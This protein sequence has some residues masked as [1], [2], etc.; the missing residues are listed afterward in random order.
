MANVTT[1]KH[2]ILIISDVS[3]LNQD[4]EVS[5][6][7]RLFEGLTIPQLETLRDHYIT[8]G[9]FILNKSSEIIAAG[10][11]RENVRLLSKLVKKSANA[12]NMADFCV[13]KIYLKRRG[14]K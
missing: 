6:K 4:G 11:A 10:G 9:T 2:G 14:V 7:S 12:F 3:Y 1:D 8:V 13:L 5:I